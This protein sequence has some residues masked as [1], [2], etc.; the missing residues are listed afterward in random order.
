MFDAIFDIFGAIFMSIL[1]ALGLLNFGFWSIQHKTRARAASR[2][3]LFFS[4]DWQRPLRPI[5][6]FQ[7]IP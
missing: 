1:N 3:G 6:I 2:H 5:R 7:G 4:T